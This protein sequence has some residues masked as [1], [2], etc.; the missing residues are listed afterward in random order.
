MKGAKESRLVEFTHQ[1][2]IDNVMKELDTI[3]ER[4]TSE[5][6]DKLDLKTFDHKSY[7]ACIYGQMTGSCISSRASEIYD[8][9][10]QTIAFINDGQLIKI[11]TTDDHIGSTELEHFLFYSTC[12]MHRNIIDYLKGKRETLTLK[13]KSQKYNVDVSTI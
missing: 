6:I 5:E 10:V 12:E 9:S 2:F 1:E 8:K 7:M 3:K 13:F 4:A 11:R